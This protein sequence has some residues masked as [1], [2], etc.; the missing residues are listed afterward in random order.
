MEYLESGV[1]QSTSELFKIF[2]ALRSKTAVVIRNNGKRETVKV[3]GIVK[4]DVS[5]TISSENIATYDVIKV[6]L[7][8]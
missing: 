8:T 2:V 5:I 4:G 7:F 1:L 6:A 3:N